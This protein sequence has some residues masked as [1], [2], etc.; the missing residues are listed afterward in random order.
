MELIDPHIF[1]RGVVQP[2]ITVVLSLFCLFNMKI[3]LQSLHPQVISS[4][5]CANT[6][7]SQSFVYSPLGIF[8]SAL[9]LVVPVAKAQSFCWAIDRYCGV[10]CILV[11]GWVWGRASHRMEGVLILEGFWAPSYPLVMADIAI[12]NGYL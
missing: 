2:P 1:Q 9:V 7:F 11:G 5:V 4:F 6:H 12:E 10:V 8:R 3:P